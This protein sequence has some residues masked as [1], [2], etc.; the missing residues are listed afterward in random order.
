MAFVVQ[1]VGVG[2]A[3]VRLC[4]LSIDFDESTALH[5]RRNTNDT[6]SYKMGQRISVLPLRTAQKLV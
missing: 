6:R 4:T 1:G 3:P 2:Q 5:S